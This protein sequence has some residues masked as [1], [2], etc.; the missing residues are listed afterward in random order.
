[1]YKIEKKFTVPIGHRLKKH[2]GRCH[3]IHGHNFTILVGLEAHELNDNDMII[4][5]SDLKRLVNSVLDEYDHT[6]LVNKEDES[7]V[8]PL[9]DKLGIRFK[10]FDDFDHDPTAEKL[11]EKL[12]YDIQDVLTPMNICVDYVTVYENENSKA[13]YS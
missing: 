11:S 12:Y 4:D 13:T 7:W 6:L 8:K 3:S 10:V 2:D 5:F 9:V 1:M